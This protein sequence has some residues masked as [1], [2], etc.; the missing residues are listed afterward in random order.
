MHVVGDMEVGKIK[1]PIYYDISHQFTV[2]QQGKD[3]YMRG[4]RASLEWTVLPQ[5]QKKQHSVDVENSVSKIVEAR[6]KFQSILLNTIRLE[7]KITIILH[8]IY[9]GP[10]A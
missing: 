1:H 9:T 10:F 2:N 7:C 6:S 4:R 5:K 3:D 8:G